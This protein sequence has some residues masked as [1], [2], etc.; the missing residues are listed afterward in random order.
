MNQR[1]LRIVLVIIITLTQHDINL[2]QQNIRYHYI[3]LTLF[4]PGNNDQ[5]QYIGAE[6]GSV[7]VVSSGLQAHHQP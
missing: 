3:Y 4:D 6:H 2:L 5:V 1:W 7:Q